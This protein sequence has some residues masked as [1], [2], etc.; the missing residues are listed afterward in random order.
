MLDDIL[1]KIEEEEIASAE[2][3]RIDY[4]QSD[5]M[6]I[7]QDKINNEKGETNLYN[8]FLFN[9]ITLHFS[10]EEIKELRKALASIEDL[11]D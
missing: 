6:E 3:E 9:S 8:I 1:K 4:Y 5:L 11:E 7:W 2:N 10:L